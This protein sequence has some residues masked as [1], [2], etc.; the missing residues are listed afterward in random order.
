MDHAVTALIQLWRTHPSEEL[1]ALADS[2]MEVGIDLATRQGPG[3]HPIGSVA[4][5]ILITAATWRPDAATSRGMAY[6]PAVDRVV[7]MAYRL[8]GGDVGILNQVR[9][10]IGDEQWVAHRNLCIAAQ[11]QR[12]N[13]I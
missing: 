2:L 7:E 6:P 9:P 13:L 1:E 8:P 11:G 10:I 3:G 12:L 4:A 5:N